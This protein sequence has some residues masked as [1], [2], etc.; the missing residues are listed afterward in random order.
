MPSPVLP[1]QIEISL[2]EHLARDEISG[3]IEAY[4]PRRADFFSNRWIRVNEARPSDMSQ[5][6]RITER[7]RQI[8]RSSSMYAWEANGRLYRLERDQAL[9]AMYHIDIVKNAVRLLDLDK[10]IPSENAKEFKYLMPTGF[11]LLVA[12]YTEAYIEDVVPRFRDDNRTRPRESLRVVP[13]FKKRLLTLLEQK[14]GI[15]KPLY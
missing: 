1:T 11:D 4:V 5:L 15:N 8:G 3:V 2:A 14:L 6:R 10:A 9:L 13:M 12:R 7:T